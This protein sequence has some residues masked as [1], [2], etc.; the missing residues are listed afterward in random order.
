MQSF[1][2]NEVPGNERYIKI[3]SNNRKHD[4]IHSENARKAIRFI[5]SLR[6]L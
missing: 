1:N 6:K 4:K 2:Q 5:V 3:I